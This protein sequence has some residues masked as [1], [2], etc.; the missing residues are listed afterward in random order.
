MSNTTV[1]NAAVGGPGPS[2]AAGP[3]SGPGNPY[4]ML[5]S[6]LHPATRLPL[7]SGGGI[8]ATCGGCAHRFERPTTRG[9][10][11]KCAASPFRARGGADVPADFPACQAYTAAPG[12]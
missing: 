2:P 6:G 12:R 9:P 8:E 1:L 11:D 7:L 3:V 5:R 4:A 10:R